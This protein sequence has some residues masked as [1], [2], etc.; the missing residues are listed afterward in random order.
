MALKIKYDFQINKHLHPS[1]K[2]IPDPLS[3]HIQTHP[4][5]TIAAVQI[6]KSN[7]IL[8]ISSYKQ[9]S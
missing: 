7:V 9:S 1:S 4:S 2:S 8:I 5:T 3:T 6:A